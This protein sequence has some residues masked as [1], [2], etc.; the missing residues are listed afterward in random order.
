MPAFLAL[1]PGKD[2]LYIGLFIAILGGLGWVYHRGEQ[3]VEAQDA[4]LAAI[5]QKKVTTVET[6]ATSTESQNA[7]IWKQAVSIPPVPDIGIVCHKASGSVLPAADAGKGAS[8]DGDADS[9]VGPPYDPSGAALTRA[10]K[11]DAQIKYLQARI[12]ELES[13]MNGAP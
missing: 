10:H 3:H 4:K 5:D 7:L 6:A 2:W 13:E 8:T 1:I 9:G 12:R 11:A